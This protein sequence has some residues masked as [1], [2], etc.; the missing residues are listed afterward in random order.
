MNTKL[1]RLLVVII[2]MVFTGS[3]SAKAQESGRSLPSLAP[4]YY[5]LGSLV[6]NYY[7]E[8][9]LTN[10]DHSIHFEYRARDFMIHEPL[11]TGD[12]QDARTERGP[13]TKGVVCDITLLSGKYENNQWIMIR[14]PSGHDYW[15]FDK[16]YYKELL[17]IVYSKTRDCHLY[18][19]LR[20]PADADQQFIGKFDNLISHFEN[21][22][23]P[24]S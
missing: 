1:T 16:R 5:D 18:V 13:N 11:M 10:G 9:S 14:D 12:W 21:H 2:A 15:I 19:H 7:P 22:L 3:L 24:N 6:R 8:A 4:F 20:V 23:K 17:F